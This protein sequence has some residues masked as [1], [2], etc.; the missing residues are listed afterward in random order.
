MRERARGW[1]PKEGG[2]KKNNKRMDIDDR[3]GMRVGRRAKVTASVS[4]FS[5]LV[6]LAPRAHV[7]P[8]DPF[9]IG[10]L[11]LDRAVPDLVRCEGIAPSGISFFTLG[12]RARAD[13]KEREGRMENSRRISKRGPTSASW[14]SLCEVLTKT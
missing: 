1:D 7:R 9:D 12:A 10:F 11:L 13:Q 5:E 2:V 3:K 8:E 4:S 6:A 14:T